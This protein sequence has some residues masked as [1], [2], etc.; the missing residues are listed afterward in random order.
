[1]THI[2]SVDV[3]QNRM[4]PVPTLTLTPGPYL[5]PCFVF[6]SEDFMLFC[7]VLCCRCSYFFL[8]DGS[9]VKGEGDL[10]REGICYF[11]PERVCDS[12]FP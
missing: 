12:K 10:T 2:I 11:Y 4:G 3:S 1:M 8:Y 6:A 9:K 7:V 5:P